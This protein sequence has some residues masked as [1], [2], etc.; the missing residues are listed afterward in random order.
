LQVYCTLQPVLRFAPFLSSS[1]IAPTRLRA[2]RPTPLA[3]PGSAV[4]LHTLQSFPLVIRRTASPRPLPSRRFFK[5]TSRLCSSDK[6]VVLS[7]CCHQTGPAALLGFV[8]LQ[9]S[10]LSFSL[11]AECPTR[12]R[13]YPDATIAGAPALGGLDSKLSVALAGFFWFRMQKQIA[14]KPLSLPVF[15]P[16]DTF[17]ATFPGLFS[18]THLR[19]NAQEDTQAG[20]P[21]IILLRLVALLLY[22]GLPNTDCLRYRDRPSMPGH[23]AWPKATDPPQSPARDPWLSYFYKRAERKKSS[24]HQSAPNKSL[25]TF[26]SV[27]N[28]RTPPV[29]RR[30]W[31]ILI[32][33]DCRPSWGFVRQRST[34]G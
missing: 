10:P 16:T 7:W 2:V 27:Q 11:H 26:A 15:I 12:T 29:S 20:P 25:A 19:A 9:G 22:F 28:L 21:K 34:W 3:F 24:K 4:F 14:L 23:Q 30:M 31:R 8:P 6:S 32:E 13:S 1:V 33:Q 5:S 17:A 18:C